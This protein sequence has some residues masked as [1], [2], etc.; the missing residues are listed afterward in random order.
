LER[1]IQD[2]VVRV[3]AL[4]TPQP[5]TVIENSSFEAAG[6]DDAI[7]GWTAS[8]PAG[9]RVAIDRRTA[10]S[11]ANAVQLTGTGAAVSLTSAPF[12]PPTTGRLA[13]EVYLRATDAAQPPSLRIAV[14]G[15]LA[16]GVFDPHGVIN[17][18]DTSAAPNGWE[19]YRFPIDTLPLEGLSELRL[20]FDLLGAGEIWIDDVQVYDLRFDPPELLELGKLVGLASVHLEKGQFVDCSRLLDGYWP[21]F[22]VANVPLANNNPVAARPQPLNLPPP[23]QDPPKKGG[24]LESLRSYVPR[25]R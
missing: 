22:L 23:P 17:R 19:L 2:L 9:S 10:H 11:G 24:V 15:K 14:E 16:G 1:R 3:R 18:I 6:P 7:A 20:R 21:R 8:A 12:A 13:I 5:L 25:F 4:G